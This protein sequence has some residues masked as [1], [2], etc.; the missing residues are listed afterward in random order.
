MTKLY[1]FIYEDGIIKPTTVF[2]TVKAGDNQRDR[3]SVRFLSNLAMTNV[4]VLFG[5]NCSALADFVD[6]CAKSIY[7]NDE[8]SYLKIR[9]AFINA[10]DL[11]KKI[12]ESPLCFLNGNL[13]KCC[14]RQFH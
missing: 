4:N 7:P 1:L 9:R 5:V 3:A 6:K 10:R 14:Q 8:Q 2:Y 12:K 13:V 11:A